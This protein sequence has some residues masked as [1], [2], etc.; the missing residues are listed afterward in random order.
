MLKLLMLAP[1]CTGPFIN[2]MCRQFLEK[3][4]MLLIK[5]GTTEITYQL[6]PLIIVV[7]P[8]GGSY[9]LSESSFLKS[10]HTGTTHVILD[11]VYFK[12]SSLSK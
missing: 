11:S 1:L 6:H 12:F 9:S 5:K 2:S 3:H 10:G 4:R 8:A 7:Y